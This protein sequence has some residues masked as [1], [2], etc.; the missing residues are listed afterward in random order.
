MS[1]SRPAA[2]RMATWALRAGV[3]AVLL[4]GVVVAGQIPFGKPSDKAVARLALRTVHTRLE[5]CRDRTAEELATLPT[6]MRQP[7]VCEGISPTYRLVLEVDGREVLTAEADAGG[8]RGDRPLIVD[9]EV[10]VDPGYRQ[11]RVSMA[12]VQT[13]AALDEASSAAWAEIPRYGLEQSV[14]LTAGHITLVV[15]DQDAN[16]LKIYSPS[17]DKM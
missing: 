12:P 10:E 17:A 5:V 15:L 13:N 8:A 7:R 4:A 6:H 2:A 14:E 3:T 9:E 11:L 1:S 16:R